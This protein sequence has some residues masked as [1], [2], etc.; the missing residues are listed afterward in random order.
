MHKRVKH[1]ERGSLIKQ[2]LTEGDWH[3]D[4]KIF[5]KSYF[6]YGSRP[7]YNSHALLA[8]IRQSVGPLNTIPC[9]QCAREYYIALAN[10]HR[11]GQRRKHISRAYRLLRIALL[12]LFFFSVPLHFF[13]SSS[14]KLAVRIQ[15]SEEFK[16]MIFLYS[17]THYIL[18][19]C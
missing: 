18:V 4:L 19:L 14:A 3:S 12:L 11:H 17:Q 9:V 2:T 16:L 6:E 7:I 1:S 15:T 8:V 5:L 13:L 10:S